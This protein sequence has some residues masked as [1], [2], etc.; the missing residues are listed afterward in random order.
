MNNKQIFSENLKRCMTIKNVSRQDLSKVLG[1]SYFTITDWVNGKKYPRID[2]IEQLAAYFSISKSDLIEE[3][4]VLG[5]NIL[6]RRKELGMT[7]E[8]LARELGYKSKS[9]INKIELGI[10]DVQQ[11]K[12]A[13][14]A[15]VLH[16]TSAYLMGWTEESKKENPGALKLTDRETKMVELFRN[17]PDNLQQLVLEILFALGGKSNE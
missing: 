11:S 12:I 5:K 14:F 6:H 17:V 13:G 2:K 3:K 10:N 16:T 8:E 7:Q 4:N 1:V 9:T 15:E